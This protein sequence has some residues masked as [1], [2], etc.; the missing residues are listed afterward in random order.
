MSGTPS[1]GFIGAGRVTRLMLEGL[2]RANAPLARVFVSDVNVET[3]RATATA[4][5]GVEVVDPTVAA[6]CDVVVIAVPPPI[7]PGVLPGLMASLKPDAIVLSLA[8]KHRFADLTRLLGGFARVAR[9]NPNAPSIVGR[10]F[11]PIA[12]APAL[13]ATD[14]ARLL[15]AFSPLGATPEVDETT[16]EAYAVISA[17]GPTYL[18]FQFDLL[19]KMGEE[20]GLSAEAARVA[21][22]TMVHGATSALLESDLP[23]KFTMDLV[24]GRPMVEDQPRITEMYRS[25]LS[26]V[27]AKLTT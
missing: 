9:M 22:A 15:D 10:G 21:V 16:L 18:W 1:F 5:P 14:R 12:F 13:T 7:V 4:V 26:A 8:P 19:R 17:M 20:F 3:A 23:P 24:S 6:A 25:R 2:A 27:Y 11:N